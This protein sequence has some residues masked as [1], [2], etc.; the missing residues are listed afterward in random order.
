[1]S[2]ASSPAPTWRKSTF[3]SQGA[4]VEVAD[5]GSGSIAVR[6]SNRPDDGV[7]VFTR[8]EIDAFVRGVFAGEFDDFR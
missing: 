4:C 2:A 7:V 1:V 3:S 5:L 6:N 8:R